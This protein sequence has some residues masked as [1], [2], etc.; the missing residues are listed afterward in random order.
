M[1]DTNATA[2][3]GIEHIVSN[4]ETCQV[5]LDSV[6]STLGPYGRDKLICKGQTDFHVS[7]DGAFI[8]SNLK[9]VHPIPH[10]VREVSIAQDKTIGDGTTTVCV[11]TISLLNS[12]KPLILDKIPI[13]TIKKY[14]VEAETIMLA[15]ISKFST[16]QK[17]EE[18]EALA[19]KCAET[20]LTSKLISEK[21]KKVS[22]MVLQ[23]LNPRF[24][25]SKNKLNAINYQTIP[26]DNFDESFLF[27]GVIFEKTFSYAGFERMPK[28][29]SNIAIALIEIELELSSER[30][31]AEARISSTSEYKKIVDAEFLLFR[32]KMESLKQAAEK[33]NQ[34]LGIVLSSYPVGDFAT[35]WFSEQGIFSAGR[36]RPED[37]RKISRITGAKV[38]RKS[39]TDLINNISECL[40]EVKSFEERQVGDSRL[41]FVEGKEDCES[42][43]VLRGGSNG[44]LEEA[45]RAINDAVKISSVVLKSSGRK[46][47]GAGASEVMM[48]H[49]LRKAKFTLEGENDSMI[50]NIVF[51]KVAE[52]LE[53]LPEIIADNAGYDGKEIVGSMKIALKEG[54]TTGINLD[55]GEIEENYEVLE[56]LESKQTMIRNAIETSCNVISIGETI[57][58]RATQNIDE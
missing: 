9:L 1:L 50:R 23:A 8:L 43:F 5:L 55:K 25:G 12:L 45:I 10:L 33:N 54:K 20:A 16:F 26:G 2:D 30:E 40:G 35:Q 15:S 48:A 28:R 58:D 3:S 24:Q 4:I 22:E 32:E 18:L 44:Y 29:F 36:V 56:P 39:S 13:P 51:E 52:S 31:T 46:V 14:L 34:Q 41:N 19:L 6:K 11:F 7:N 42:T 57:K 17:E 38:F 37:M 53:K 21:K 27:K 47:L 49:S